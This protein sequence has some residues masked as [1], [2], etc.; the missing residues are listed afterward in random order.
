M[1]LLNPTIHTAITHYIADHV[2]PLSHPINIALT[3]KLPTIVA[4][5][6]PPLWLPSRQLVH[7]T[8][9]VGADPA[10]AKRKMAS[11]VI[12]YEQ[13]QQQQHQRWGHFC[14]RA[15]RTQLGDGTAFVDR[16]PQTQAWSKN[17]K[18]STD[19]VIQ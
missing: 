14:Y 18:H 16:G 19:G 17:A 5:P 15:A 7:T 2:L 3:V 4:L 6:T 12:R 10:R 13:Q 11:T 8:P 9:A 1:K